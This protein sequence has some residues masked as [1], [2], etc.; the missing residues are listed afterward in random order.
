MKTK[1][2]IR[3]ALVASIYI[4]LTIMVAPI[5]YQGIQFRISEVLLILV[6]YDK[7]YIIPLVM[8]CLIANIFSP[9][10]FIDLLFGSTASF[11]S[12]LLMYKFRNK[13]FIASLFPAF[14][15]GILVGIELT[16]VFETPILLNML[17]VFLGEF[18][19]VSIFGMVLFKYLNKNKK[20]IELIEGVNHE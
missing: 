7:L 10:G 16:I 9:L 19:V 13:K 12:L 14:I 20:F 2:F 3:M 1:L 4:V 8:G 11:V 6:F 15:N 18:L 17:T 5:S